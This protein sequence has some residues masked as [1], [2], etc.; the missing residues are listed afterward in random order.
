MTD[1]YDNVSGADPLAATGIPAVTPVSPE[2]TVAATVEPS[3]AAPA[4]DAISVPKRW[5]A[6]GGWSLLALVVASAIFTA[7]VAVGHHASGRADQRG[8][9]A[10]GAPGMRGPGGQPPQMRGNSEGPGGRDG[11]EQER[12]RGER[13]PEAP[14]GATAP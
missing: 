9:F 6:I 8:V 4:V 2:P 12:G 11:F 13:L 10:A 3:S 5:L 1:Q 14:D 7:G